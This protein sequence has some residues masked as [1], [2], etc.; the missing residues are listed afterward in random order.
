MFKISA[1]RLKYFTLLAFLLC[2]F[3]FV[4][5]QH[6][7][8]QIVL[9]DALKK[10]T[11]ENKNVFVIFHASWCGWCHKMD[12]SMNDVSCKKMFD[13]NY[14]ITHLTV[15]ESADKKNL[16]TPGADAIRKQYHGEQ[17]GLPFWLILDKKGNLLADSRII[18]PGETVAK[19]QSNTGCPA[20]REEVA[21]LLSVL[22]KTSK[23]ND[24]EL[25]V[26]GER[27]SKNN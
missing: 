13:A 9:R 20:A 26:I 3:T 7:A 6:S 2:S 14:V 19:P 5:A 16:E 24:A 10:A 18:A 22:K 17:E 25:K 11:A 15:D 21:Y 23:L 8:T 12:S 1:M 4:T 27:F